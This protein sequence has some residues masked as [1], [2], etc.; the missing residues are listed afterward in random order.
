MGDFSS[1][2]VAMQLPNSFLFLPLVALFAGCQPSPKWEAEAER[3]SK[4]E[5]GKLSAPAI[6]QITLEKRPDG[7]MYEPGAEK[8]FTGKDV[9]PLLEGNPP[10]PREGFS[11]VTPY[12]DGKIHGAKES[13]FP[14]GRLREARVYENGIA[15]QS[16]VYFP[17]GAKK[18]FVKLNAK[19]VA[20]GEYKRWHENG[21]LHTDGAHNENERFQGEFKEYDAEGKLT[22]H[23]LWEAG[24]L[25]KI[26][27]E[28]PAQ[29]EERL[30]KYGKMEGEP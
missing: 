25:K 5:G 7:L 21:Q 23:Y 19:D 11:V 30:K 6:D 4:S 2:R 27:F 14:S 10:Q 15:R 3:A 18:I 16:T 24:V 9:E 12:V 20:E 1:Y 17:S 13:Y 29:K 26:F 8:P 22:G 28:S